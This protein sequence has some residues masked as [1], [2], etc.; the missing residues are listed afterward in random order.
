MKFS[1]KV[2]TFLLRHWTLVS[3]D[4]NVLSKI[5]FSKSLTRYAKKTL[6]RLPSF[7]VACLMPIR[8]WP[9]TS[10]Q[11]ICLPQRSVLLNWVQCY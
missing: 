10:R 8:N 4:F 11:L 6:R 1:P 7:S 2:C 3:N 5:D 9:G